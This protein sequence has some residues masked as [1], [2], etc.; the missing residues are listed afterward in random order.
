M[1]KKIYTVAE[2]AREFGRTEEEIREAIRSGILSAELS[3]NIGDYLIR[4]QDLATFLKI[5]QKEIP[6]T[7]RQ[8]ILII[9]DEVNF[10][11]VV[12][13]E[14]ERDARLSV[15]YASWGRD[16]IRMAQE[17]KPDLVLID[18]MLPDTTGDE[19]LA[20]IRDLQA[21]RNTKVVVYSA[22]TREAIAQHPNL[23]ERLRSMGAD[24]FM[25]KS[26]GL[27]ALIIKVYSLLGLETNTRVVRKPGSP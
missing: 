5:T 10:A 11:N 6:A 19:V 8:K 27:R 1:E 13:L 24:E 12:K 20:S 23:E 9:D 25:S 15:R 2:A 14:L 4:S 26:A 3:H 16:G 18:F 22:H 17:F 21:F 7:P